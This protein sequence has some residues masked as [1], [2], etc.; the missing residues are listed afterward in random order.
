MKCEVNDFVLIAVEGSQALARVNKVKSSSLTVT[1]NGKHLADPTEAKGSTIKIEPGNVMINF[2]LTP[3]EGKTVMG[4][5]I[6]PYYKT[7]HLKRWGRL[8]FMRFIS[9]EDQQKFINAFNN[10]M[11]WVRKSGLDYKL[12]IEI[13]VLPARGGMYAGAYIFKPDTIDTMQLFPKEL[14]SLEFLITHEFGHHIWERFF[15]D[16]DR[17]VWI[18][19]FNGSVQVENIDAAKLKRMRKDLIESGLLKTYKKELEDADKV[20]WKEIIRHI[21]SVHHLDEHFLQIMLNEKDDL[22]KIWP[23]HDI[24][25]SDV[26][27]FVS[28]YARKNP[29]EMFCESLAHFKSEMEMHP[30]VKKQI[31]RTLAALEAANVVAT[32]EAA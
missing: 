26:S 1:L 8:H 6:Q 30:T 10:V 29:A 28:N 19:L 5:R 16:A 13:E 14:V 25:I 18:D 3:P 24:E 2:G 12:P 22:R 20:V 9:D 27:L 21:K 4:T 31:K 23:K 17:K 32:K 11:K 7:Y 15:T